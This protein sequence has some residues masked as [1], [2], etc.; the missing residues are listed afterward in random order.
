M[1]TKSEKIKL[2]LR[3]IRVLLKKQGTEFWNKVKSQKNDVLGIILKILIF[4]GFVGVFVS[5]FYRFSDVYLNVKI[6]GVKDYGQRAYEMLTILYGV[7]FVIM[8]VSGVFQIDK[9]LFKGDENLLYSAMPIPDISLYFSRII[10]VYI[11]Q[12][13]VCVAFVFTVNVTYGIKLNQPIGYYFASLLV[14]F[15]LPFLSI[16]VASFIVLPLKKILLFFRE[17]FTLSF[18]ALNILVAIF[19]VGYCFLLR[20][21]EQVLVG[22]DIRYFFDERR[23][24]SIIN[25]VTHAYPVCW[26]AGMTLG[27]DFLI[28]LVASLGLTVG[29]ILISMV[30][31]RLL[32][33]SAMQKRTDSV[34]F[35][36]KH[37]GLKN[38]KSPAFALLKKELLIIF[39]TPD[40]AFS[41]LSVALVMPLIIFFSVSLTSDMVTSLVGVNTSLELSLI[42]TVLFV[43]LTNTFCATGINRDREMFYSIKAMP[44]SGRKVMFVKVVSAML[45][46]LLSNVANSIVLGA[47]GYLDV[48]GA[49]LV[50]FVGVAIAF[51]QI[52]F[53]TRSN[54][55][56]PDFSENSGD[57]ATNLVSKIITFG[58]ISTIV[59]GALLLYFKISQ[60]LQGIES[61]TITYVILVVVSVAL[62]VLGYVYMIRK[63]RRKYYEVSGGY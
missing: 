29:C 38:Q 39:R 50:L 30:A 31:T 17:R 15:I 54:L 32:F 47:T 45:I 42:L 36:R 34:N 6:Y 27:K 48:G 59:V 4:T 23:M 12:L 56:F 44:I 11:K 16:S 14:T 61:S 5:V 13:V 2:N 53:A 46:A 58:L 18:V 8:I 52:C 21:V 28:N 51:A 25:F 9:S 49:F 22:E 35:N 3:L 24:T 26:L 60:S 10:S 63:L 55:N 43:S 7:I 19:V 33:N 37:I 57:K 20:G 40:Y 62:A 41:Y 1:N